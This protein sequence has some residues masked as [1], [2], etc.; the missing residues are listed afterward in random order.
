MG[1]R[2]L[3]VTLGWK[4]LARAKRSGFLGPFISHKENEVFVNVA[5]EVIFTIPHF[6]R[7]SQLGQIS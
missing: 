1:V 3:S 7:K 5:P 6:L 4:K 2:S